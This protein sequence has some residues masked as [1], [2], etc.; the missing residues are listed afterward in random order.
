ML[1]LGA[2]GLPLASTY[3]G[4]LKAVS[5]GMAKDIAAQ[6]FGVSPRNYL[7]IQN[8]G[9][10]ARWM[11]DLFLNPNNESLAVNN[12]MATSFLPVAGRLVTPAMETIE[13]FSPQLNVNI[14]VPKLWGT[15]IPTSD[16][17]T[18]PMTDLLNNFL[19]I[20]GV[21]VGDPGHAGAQ[22]KMTVIGSSY[23]SIGGA[24]ADTN[25]K[26]IPAVAA[27]VQELRFKSRTDA[28]LVSMTAGGLGK[29]LLQETFGAFT[30]AEG[31]GA[32]ISK[33]D[34]ESSDIFKTADL[35]DQ[36]IKTYSG[37]LEQ[38]RKNAIDFITA[39]VGDLNTSWSDLYLKYDALVKRALELTIPGINDLPL[40]DTA[41]RTGDNR[42]CI[43]ATDQIITDPDLRTMIDTNHGTNPTVH[44]GLADRFALAEF[45]LMNG[46]SSCIHIESGAIFNLHTTVNGVGTMSF[47][48]PDQH[49]H[50]IYPTTY[51]NALTFCA[52][53]ACL[54]ELISQLKA[55]N[56]FN[57]TVIQMGGEFNRKPRQ[58]GT[59]SDHSW[60][61]SNLSIWNGT[62]SGPM[63][64]GNLL[65]HSG[66]SFERAGDYPGSWGFGANV[67]GG[68]TI[69]INPGHVIAS[70]AALLGVPNPNPNNEAVL[71]ATESGVF[72][73]LG[74]PL[75][76]DN[77]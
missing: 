60:Q 24:V 61:S 76:E 18:A 31:D 52:I 65:K 6:G 41:S 77:T 23:A 46:Y 29:N 4:F 68:G 75:T 70:M 2:V 58:D 40:G 47:N 25:P 28:S 34:A 22:A 21:D 7:F 11:W 26:L 49:F 32:F 9:A 16:G 59:G 63:I 54:L 67:L 66:D 5:A 39:G 51:L 72:S 13:V 53:S 33:V 43:N 17:G 45:C 10:P 56:K 38:D 48:N 12:G 30:I 69:P 37:N 55:A 50:G 36:S 74:A 35:L 42:Y 19:T 20:R 14:R 15:S 27:D 3:L 1:G 62:I 73:L 44:F 8:A 57:N 64:I 71:Y